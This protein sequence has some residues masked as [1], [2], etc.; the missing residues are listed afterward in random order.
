M[1][2][3]GSTIL[4]TTVSESDSRFRRLRLYLRCGEEETPLKK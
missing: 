4:Y 1:Y 3:A 2:C